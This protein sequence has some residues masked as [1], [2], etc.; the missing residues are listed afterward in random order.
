MSIAIIIN[1]IAGGKRPET[2][3]AHAE[4]A[5]A[6]LGSS[7]EPGEIFV[8]ERKHHARELAAAA[9]ARGCR[10]VVAWGGDGTVNE[11]GSALVFRETA[12]AIVPA[13][14]GN[15]LARTLAVARDPK[16]AI[17]DAL[18]ATPRT[19]D[20]GDIAGHLFFSLAGVGFDAHVARCFDREQAGRRG[21][22]GY[23]RIVA[24]ELVWYRPAAY[25]ID[26]LPGAA[27][28]ALL[29]TVA[30]SPQFGNGA[31]I[32]PSARLDDGRLDLVVVEEVS[33][34][35]T[36]LAIPRLFNGRIATM[37]GVSIRQ[38]ESTTI[39]SDLPMAFHVDG[40]PFEGSTRL[41]VGIK[42]GALRVSIR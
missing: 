21:L 24:R 32:A 34:L 41:T 25:R 8:T 33:R 20:A 2:A 18:R 1:P 15:G 14:S 40:E 39:E 12:L 10:L 31:R 11:I 26:Q 37:P 13:G 16:Q 19:I 35:R 5:A 27:R 36:I 6:V 38:I 7:N 3:R 9:V 4:L 42:P 30:N 17:Q 22:A 23:V 28:T 29:V